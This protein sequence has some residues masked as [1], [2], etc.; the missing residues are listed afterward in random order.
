MGVMKLISYI[1][2]LFRFLFLQ[3]VLTSF[4]IYYFDKFLIGDYFEG[5][6]IIRDNLLEDRDRFY[7]FI[8]N[9]FIKTDIYIALFI[10]IFLIILYS[11]NFYTYVNELTYT[12]EK[13]FFDEFFP[14]YLLWTSCMFVFFYVLRF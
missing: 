3:T 4:S 8:T 12:L 11:T 13:K 2:Y 9:D 7:P 14:I 5:Y 1:K 10:F 6:L